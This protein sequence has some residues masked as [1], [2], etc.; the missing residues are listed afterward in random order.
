MKNENE[1]D[2][3][4]FRKALEETDE[5]DF[6]GHTNFQELSVRDKLIWLSEL[7]YFKSIIKK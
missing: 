7:N 3:E 4:S 6:D 5:K 1:N 2:L